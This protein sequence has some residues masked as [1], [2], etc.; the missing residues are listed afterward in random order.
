[1]RPIFHQ[2]DDS[3]IGHLIGCFLALRLK[4]DRST[5]SAGSTL[6]ASPRLAR[7]DARSRPAAG[8]DRHRLRTIAMAAASF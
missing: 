8:G 4:V 3:V 1:V 6:R 7:S 2:R 5:C